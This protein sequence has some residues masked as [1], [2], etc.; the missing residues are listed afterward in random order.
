MADRTAE[1]IP[2]LSWWGPSDYGIEDRPECRCLHPYAAR[3][4]ALDGQHWAGYRVEANDE[5]VLQYSVILPEPG[6]RSD[7]ERSTTV[8]SFAYWPMSSGEQGWAVVGGQRVHADETV[9]DWDT[10]EIQAYARLDDAWSV[11][12]WLFVADPM[13]HQIEIHGIRPTPSNW[14]KIAIKDPHSGSTKR[15]PFWRR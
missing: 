7:D 8:I 3:G 10:D 11:L 6:E 4:I 9:S 14:P 5:S 2:R 12:H 13:I 15:R 1:L